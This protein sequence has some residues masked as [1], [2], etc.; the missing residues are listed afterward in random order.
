[1]K[2]QFALYGKLRE[3]GYIMKNDKYYLEFTKEEIEEIRTA[4][5]YVYLLI[6]VGNSA[7]TIVKLFNFFD[8]TNRK[9]N[10]E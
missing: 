4:L 6:T 3:E 10:E 7:L 2:L 8:R 9:L 5:C 1:M